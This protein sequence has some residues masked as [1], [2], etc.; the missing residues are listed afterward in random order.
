ME[1]LKLTDCKIIDMMTEGEPSLFGIL[2]SKYQKKIINYI[3]KFVNNREIAEDI[4]QDTFL[5]AFKYIKTFNKDR[6]SFNGWLYRIA[7][8]EVC[9]YVRNNL[10][11]NQVELLEDYKYDLIVEMDSTI[12]DSIEKKEVACKINEGLNLIHSRYSKIITDRYL[13]NKSYKEL[14]IAYNMPERTI[15]TYL[16][17]G[18]K[19]LAKLQL[20]T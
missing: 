10:K 3:D 16:H 6:G 2:Y 17:R 12:I 8:N 11:I 14:A 18:L 19:Q 7:H 4:S 13:N 9:N 5:K 1:Q 20:L 15:G